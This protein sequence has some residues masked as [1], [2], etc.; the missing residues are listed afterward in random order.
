MPTHWEIEP[1]PSFVLT[2]AMYLLMEDGITP[3]FLEDG[4]SVFILEDASGASN[5]TVKPPPAVT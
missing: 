1:P 5:W 3:I 2:P 4:V